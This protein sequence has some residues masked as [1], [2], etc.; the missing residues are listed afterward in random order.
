MSQAPLAPTQLSQKSYGT[1]LVLALI[2][3]VLGVH[4]VYLKRWGEAALDWGLTVTAIALLESHP[5]IALLVFFLDLVHT[6][7][8]TSLLIMGKWHDGQGRLVAYP[9]QFQSLPPSS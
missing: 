9:G 5:G 2:F 7:V 1:A 6:A 3:G 8:T 4:H